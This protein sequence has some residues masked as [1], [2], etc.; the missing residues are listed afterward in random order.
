MRKMI[1][2]TAMISA[3]V[4]TAARAADWLYFSASD[5]IISY[6]DSSSV[7]AAGH[8]VTIWETR[9]YRFPKNDGSKSA[10]VRVHYDCAEQT[11]QILAAFLID[12]S[13]SVLA[14]SSASDDFQIVPVVPGSSGEQ[15]FEHVCRHRPLETRVNDPVADADERF[16]RA[17]GK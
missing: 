16:A 3:T 9:V 13:G 6:L 5:D 17:F 8:K 15:K 1:L 14:A 7:Q 4:G 11:T 12:G 10:K 2:L